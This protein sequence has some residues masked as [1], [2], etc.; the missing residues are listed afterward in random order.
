MLNQKCTG[1]RSLLLTILATA[2]VGPGAW[3]QT[4]KVLHQFGDSGDGQMPLAGQIL[5]GQGNLYGVTE[6]G[7]SGGNECGAGCGTVYQLKPNSDGS[8]TETVI[9]AFDGSDG[10]Y[11]FSS[12]VF[13]SH[14]NIDGTTWAVSYGDNAGFVYQLMPSSNGTWT[15]S[16]LHQF[17]NPWE[18]GEPSE[19]IFDTAGNI[20]GAATSGGLNDTGTIFSLN[21]S[22][23]WPERLLRTFDRYPSDGGGGPWGAVVFD[24]NGNLYGSTFLEGRYNAGVVFKLTN[25]GS[26]FW[27]ETVLH[28]FT[29]A[30]DGRSGNGVVFGPDGSLYGVTEY[31]G[32]LGNAYCSFGCGTVFKLTPGSD[33][34]WTETVLHS[35]RGGN[36]DGAFPTRHVT[37]DAAGNV[38]G[39]TANGGSSGS[40]YSGCGTVFKL[41][42]SPDG[43][44]TEIILHS[45]T[46]GSDGSNPESSLAID[47]AGSLYGTAYSGGLY[48]YG[49]AYEITP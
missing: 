14:G 8:W 44:W 31:G 3:G 5:D 49:V 13:D 46:G 29:G 27:H 16:V 25:Q 1:V 21:R 26:G 22:S 30:S 12:P 36:N 43:Q 24:A 47:G 19:L 28:T 48:G 32:Y 4:F 17:A 2:L 9:Y 20:Y 39:T 15:E 6:Y 10:A 37:F 7:P 35:F 40:C 23:G 42:P 34:T 38:Y 41:T 11:P 45:F 18:G 33:G